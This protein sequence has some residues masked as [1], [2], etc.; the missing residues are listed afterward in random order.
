[1]KK[2]SVILATFNEEKNIKGCLDSVRQL[3]DEIVVVDGT[4]TDKTVEMARKYTP[5]IITKDNPPMFH[6]N[7]QLAIEKAEGEWILYLD[8]D[9]RVSPELAK[10]I[11]ATINKSP[12]ENGFH[13]PR[14]NIIFGKW[15]E[16]TGWYPDYQLRLFRRG[17]AKLPCKS[18]HEQP[19]LEGDAGKLVSPLIHYNYRTVFQF[20]DKLNRLYTENDKKIYLHQKKKIV[21]LD[22]LRM[23]VSEFTKRFFYEKGY[24]DGLHGL[25]L[26]LLQA[27]SALI[28][29]AKIWEE[30]DFKEDKENSYIE[31]ME[32]E[33]KKIFKDFNFWILSAKKD[34]TK[35]VI[36]KTFYRIR[37][38]VGR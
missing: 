10:E 32:I 3:A 8:A 13:I 19:E 38:R 25:V 21:W 20:V 37:R 33:L 23:P 28:T 14:K 24:K 22:S 6:L 5:K 11:T 17:K 12:S 18:L 36:K 15:I 31:K 27:F 2:L 16:N 26:S 34:E 9:E 30:E 4:S 7:K 1:M 29:F 35:N